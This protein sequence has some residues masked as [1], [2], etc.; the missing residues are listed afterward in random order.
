VYCEIGLS[1]RRL[2]LVFA[3]VVSNLFVK[4]Q[5]AFKK[6]D[7]YIFAGCIV[8]IGLKKPFVKE[9]VYSLGVFLLP[10]FQWQASPYISIVK[11]YKELPPRQMAQSSLW[12]GNLTLCCLLYARGVFLLLWE[13]TATVNSSL[14]KIFLSY[15]LQTPSHRDYLFLSLPR[16]F[17]VPARLRLRETAC[18]SIFLN[19]LGW[20]F[21]RYSKPV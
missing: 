11:W 7:I 15:D 14:A 13:L 17:P 2:V 10:K 4:E 5:V 18:V 16:D 20:R 1:E 9:Q 6:K 3:G 19:A 8:K 21:P 12:K